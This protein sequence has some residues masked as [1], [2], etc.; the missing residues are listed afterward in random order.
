MKRNE[1]NAALRAYVRER[2]SPLKEER[3]LVSAIYGSIQDILG[4]KSCLQIG[5][6]ARFTAIRPIHDLDVLFIIGDWDPEAHDPTESLQRLERELIT[7]YKN[8]T[9][10][11]VEIRRQ[12]H[13]VSISYHANGS[14]RFAVD[15][16]PSYVWKKN[17][18]GDDMYVI[19]ELL[20]KSRV[21][22]LELY[23]Q[24]RTGERGSMTWIATDPRGYTSIA[25]GLNRVNED[26]RKTVKLVKK[27]KSC[28]KE[29]DATFPLKSFHLEQIVTGYFAEDAHLDIFGGV[30]RFY[31]DL[32][33]W[34]QKAQI[35][36][37]ADG[38]RHIDAYID[39]LT[40]EERD[41][42]LQ[43]R[44][45][46]L[47]ALEEFLEEDSVESLVDA[48]GRKRMSRSEAY[49][50]DS[51]IPMLTEREL[52]ITATV[53]PRDGGFREYVL[54]TLGLIQ[55]DRKIRFRVARDLG[56][57]DLY[58]WKVKNDDSS[59]QPRGEITDHRTAGDPEHT[60]FK[61][62]HFVECFAIRDGVCVARAKQLVCLSRG[63]S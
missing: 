5:S 46:F 25:A 24:L 16:V 10:F 52:A 28:C 13:S 6:F 37:R 60:Q 61:G 41:G 4:E 57:I 17:E 23:R 20:L 51:A 48:N 34:I 43:A 18:F 42:I 39:D 14:E 12:T 40:D 27:W 8:P 44:D 59:P 32:P 29:R 38:T 7:G 56:A 58:K 21:A 11:H 1:L 2:L 35:P 50:F 3:A 15:I 36:D 22:R 30:F 53:H 55:V 63:R 19:P 45:G 54:D 49:L 62:T 33:G 31:C 47:I 26:F 9:E